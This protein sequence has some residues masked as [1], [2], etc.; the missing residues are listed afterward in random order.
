MTN[1]S[2][3]ERLTTKSCSRSLWWLNSQISWLNLILILYKSTLLCYVSAWSNHHKRKH[4][5]RRRTC[6]R[7]VMIR[8]KKNNQLKVCIIFYYFKTASW[9]KQTSWSMLRT[10]NRFKRSFVLHTKQLKDLSENQIQATQLMKKWYLKWKLWCHWLKM[11]LKKKT[12]ISSKFLTTKQWL[13]KS[14]ETLI[15]WCCL[16]W[17]MLT[18]SNELSDQYAKK[19]ND[20]I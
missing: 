15:G 1:L 13:F 19:K 9:K 17:K 12:N 14:I 7:A 4:K 2:T 18:Q 20:T 8:C 6:E 5:N 11:N 10:S 16:F 3:Q